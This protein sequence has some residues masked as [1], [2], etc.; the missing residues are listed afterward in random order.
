MQKIPIRQLNQAQEVHPIAEQF[1][2]RRLED[3]IAD[4]DLQHPLH[5]H[6]FFFIL[7]LS[8]GSG[9]H[10]IDFMAH[11]LQDY[12]VFFLRP[13]QVHQLFL[14]VGCNGYLLEFNDEFYHPKDYSSQQRLRKASNRNFCRLD[15]ES[16]EKLQT[17]LAYIFR[18]YTNREE[19]YQNMIR[20][21]LDIFC[22]EYVRQSRN[23]DGNTLQGRTYVQERFE[24]FLELIDKNIATLKQVVGYT[25]LL[26]LSPYQLN[27]IT[28]SAVG[29]TASDLINEH[30]I[31]EA[32]RYLLATSNQ[33]KEIAELLGY[34]DVSYFIRFFKKH[35]GSS[36]D[37]FRQQFKA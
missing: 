27:E 31:L 18:E 24:D 36:P 25:D 22:T 1:K 26:H 15:A 8:K 35:A 19:G 10:E 29:K 28:K 34:E 9:S 11:E 32:K 16:F 13:G 6:S 14:K 7:A 4:K 21:N 30:I 23:T 3:I 17:A 20:S 33:I 2:I 12:S 5:R 37:A